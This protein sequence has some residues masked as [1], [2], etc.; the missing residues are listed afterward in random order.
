MEA[1]SEVLDQEAENL[2]PILISV[3]QSL[4]IS[5][6]FRPKNSVVSLNI[7]CCHVKI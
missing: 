3:E 6:N 7:R 5:V 4:F 1:V 2:L